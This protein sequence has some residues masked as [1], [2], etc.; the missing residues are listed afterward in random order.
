MNEALFNKLAGEVVADL[1][2]WNVTD[3][4]EVKAAFN[5][6]RDAVERSGLGFTQYKLEHSKGRN[7]PWVGIYFK[8]PSG[9]I[10][11]TW[12]LSQRLGDLADIASGE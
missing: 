3:D 2:R 4:P 7:P 12:R 1:Q 6:I 11:M 5:A 9:Q 10:D 8:G